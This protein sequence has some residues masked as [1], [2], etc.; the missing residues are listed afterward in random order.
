M[1]AAPFLSVER[2]RIAFHQPELQNQLPL[3][4]TA[5][6]SYVLLFEWTTGASSH[7]PEQVAR[8][9]APRF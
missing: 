6:V 8:G 9:S 7:H 5:L 1:P 4:L 3:A 2:G